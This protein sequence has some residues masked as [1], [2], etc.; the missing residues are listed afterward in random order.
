VEEEYLSKNYISR[1]IKQIIN[2]AGDELEFEIIRYHNRYSVVVTICQDHPP[3]KDCIGFG[4]HPRRKK[5][6]LR[7]ALKEL[8]TQAYGEEVT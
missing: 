6:A 7:M 3:F 1:E 2:E 4:E 8:Y 5:T